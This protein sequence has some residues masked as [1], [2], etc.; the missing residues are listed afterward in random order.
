MIA[1]IATATLE[2]CLRDFRERF[3]DNARVKKLIAGCNRDVL[4][5]PRDA[6]GAYTLTIADLEMTGVTPGITGGKDTVHMQA[7]EEIL[8]RIFTGDYNPREALIDGNMELFSSPHDRVKL[9]DIARVIWG[10]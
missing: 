7:T 3:N 2:E 8:K 1:D 6:P 5:E 10:L 9:E 4:V